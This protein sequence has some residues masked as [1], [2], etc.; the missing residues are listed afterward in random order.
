MQDFPER[1]EGMAEK[2]KFHRRMKELMDHPDRW[3][4][5]DLNALKQL[6]YYHCLLFGGSGE[7]GMVPKLGSLYSV[8]TERVT[9][10]DRLQLLDYVTRSLETNVGSVDSLIPFIFG[11]SEIRVVSAASIALA[12]H[13]PLTD[14]DPM[15]GPKT[16]RRMADN[17][18]DETALLGM[19]TGLLLLGDRRTLFLLDGCWERLGRSARA[20]LATTWGGYPYASQIDFLLGWMERA[21]D[22]ED[23]RIVGETLAMIP[24]RDGHEKVIDIERKFPVNMP[25]NL[26][27]IRMIEWWTFPEYGERIEPRL[28]AL[29]RKGLVPAVIPKI[30]RSWQIPSF[31]SVP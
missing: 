13:M 9:E 31:G 29:M 5:L 23:V 30:K 15:T 7:M 16:L 3:L 21:E 25:D 20:L 4:S 1:R 11:D 24:G 27:S 8:L 22:E 28:T 14:G 19:L 6:V 12:V 10:G 2:E 17:A 18:K 26:P